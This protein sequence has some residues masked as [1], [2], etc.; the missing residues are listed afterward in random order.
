LTVAQIL[1]W[2]DEHRARTGQWP[3]AASGP[4]GAAPGETWGALNMA[5][6]L[7]HRGLPGGDTLARLLTRER[8]APQRLGRP[9][10]PARRRLADRLRAEG[11]S[12]EEIS[13]RLGVDAD[14]IREG[15]RPPGQ[16]EEGGEG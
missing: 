3:G 11:L 7:G 5:L 4:V 16:D 13:R 9:P 10:G 6:R 12:A 2:A 8:G 14:E 1:S 15:L